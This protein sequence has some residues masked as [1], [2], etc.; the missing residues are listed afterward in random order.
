MKSLYALKSFWNPLEPQKHV[1]II[2][3]FPAS[4]LYMHV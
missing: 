1:N 3:S 4:G 2:I